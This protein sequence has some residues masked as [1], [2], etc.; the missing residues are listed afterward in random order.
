[1]TQ[2]ELSNKQKSKL[3]EHVKKD[4]RRG[5]KRG[6]ETMTDAEGP[7][8]DEQGEDGEEMDEDDEKIEGTATSRRQPRKASVLTKNEMISSLLRRTAPT[9]TSVP[10][11]APAPLVS[12]PRFDEVES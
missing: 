8:Q 2:T 4:H 3:R 5:E 1:M 6:A 10:A 7:S 11:S 9:L 12:Q